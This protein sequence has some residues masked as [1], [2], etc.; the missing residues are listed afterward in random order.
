MSILLLSS[1][2]TGLTY[3]YMEMEFSSTTMLM[4]LEY[5]DISKVIVWYKDLPG[6][7]ISLRDLEIGLA[8]AKDKEND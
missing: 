2:M 6:G 8:Q 5:L 4:T 1:Y 7:I 3:L